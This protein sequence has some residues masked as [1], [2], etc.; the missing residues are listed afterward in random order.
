[1]ST[2]PPDSR[3]PLSWDE[4]HAFLAVVQAGSIAASTRRLGVNHSTVLRRIG[5]LEH[6][7]ST[8][9]F[10]RLPGG[11]ALT[12]AG[13]EF[14]E[15]LS[16]IPEQ[17]EEAHR[18]LSSRDVEIRGT[19]RVAAPELLVKTVLMP[20]F[21]RFSL[22]YPAVQLQLVMGTQRLNLT[23]READV[24]VRVSNSPPENLVA[25]R[26]GRVQSALYASRDYLAS[27]PQGAGLADYRWVAL[28]DSLAHL[29]QAQWMERNVDP[30]RVAIQVDGVDG[31][32][33][34]VACG[35]GAGL[36]LCP[37]ADLRPEL[38][39][40]SPPDPAM[41]WSIWIL[42][43]PD[44]RQVARIRAFTEFVFDTLEAEGTLK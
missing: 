18:H 1:M 5:N 32:V 36:L 28:D 17:I 10:D 24:A 22:R 44:L 4:V 37:V 7:L 6:T 25:R 35:A 27:L 15:R 42:T 2:P 21:A 16:G 43:H 12:A 23:R 29:N 3:R 20:I 31:M 39:R 13:H 14:A 19:I 26:V 41:D 8:R 33:E 40:L 30:A 34:A 11:Y 38:V 9:L